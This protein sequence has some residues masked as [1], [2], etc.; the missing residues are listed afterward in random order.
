MLLIG[1]SIARLIV[2]YIASALILLAFRDK[3]DTYKAAVAASVIAYAIGVYWAGLSFGTQAEPAF[4]GALVIFFV[5]F[6]VVLGINVYRVHRK[7]NRN[8]DAE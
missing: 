4:K 3:K 2:L 6:L 5:P 8:A 1:F 7:L